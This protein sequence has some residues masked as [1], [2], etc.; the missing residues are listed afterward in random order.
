ML[1][2][3][4]INVRARY[5]DCDPMGYVHHS[6]YPVW[7]EVA[8]TDLLRRTG[9]TYADLEAQGVFIVVVRMNISYHKPG[10]YDDELAVTARLTRAGGAKIEHAYEVRRD[11]ALLVTATTTLACVDRDGKVVRVPDAIRGDT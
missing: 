6:V 3:I 9:V 8:R 1:S 2:T 5:V 7:F 11:G 10:C 4:T